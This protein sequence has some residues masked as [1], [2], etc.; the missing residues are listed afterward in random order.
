MKN[1]LLICQSQ[2]GSY[3]NLLHAALKPLQCNLTVVTGKTLDI[4]NG[5][6]I[7][8]APK[9][10]SASFKSRFKTWF[11]YVKFAKKFLKENIDRFDFY[12]RAKKAY[13][14]VVTGEGAIYA[15]ILLKKGVVK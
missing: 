14:V 1:V 15:N 12:D 5:V 10:N 7:V 3:I 13:A 8:E 2:D 6:T 4:E 11:S 9:Y